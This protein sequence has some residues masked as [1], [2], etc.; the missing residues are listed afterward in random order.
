MAG[1]DRP[2]TSPVHDLK[3]T[4]TGDC[5]AA[6]EHAGQTQVLHR[7]PTKVVASGTAPALAQSSAVTRPVQPVAPAPNN[8]ARPAALRPIPVNLPAG[9]LVVQLADS[10]EDGASDD[11]IKRFAIKNAPPWLVSAVVH[12]ALVIILGLWIVRSARREAVDVE[13]RYSDTLGE[14]LDV[15]GLDGGTEEDIEQVE[16]AIS[17]L[18]SVDDPFAAPPKLELALDTV[19]PAAPQSEIAAPI[20]GSPLEGRGEGM[21]KALLRAYGGDEIT[22]AAV[23]LGLGWLAR[24]QRPD[25]TWSLKGP[26]VDGS[27]YENVEAATAMALLAFQG[28]GNTHQGGKYQ[29][30]V[31][32]GIK[33]LLSRQQADG[34][35]FERGLSNARLYTDALCTIAVCELYGMTRDSLL[36]G[37]A[38]LAANYC[39]EAQDPNLGGWK[40]IPRNDSDLSVSGW[41]L[42]GLQSARMAGI[43]VP[44]SVFDQAGLFLDQ[45][46]VSGGSRYGYMVGEDYSLA[47]TAEGLLSRQY[48]GWPRTDERLLEGTSFLLENLPR[49]EDRDVYYW[50]YGTQFMHHMEGDAWKQWNKTLKPLLTDHQTTT[51]TERGSWTPLGDAPDPWGSRYGGRLYTTCLSLYMLEVYYRHMPL[52]S[53]FVQ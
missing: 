3:E 29:E 42:M 1:V 2:K 49:W 45:V 18:E 26:Y 25:G 31:S 50:Y 12:M 23:Q 13:L 28:A 52:Y 9:K 16:V 33:A 4:A 38:E 44:Q 46:S 39:V 35:F 34:S 22:E 47:M 11:A 24:Q 27:Y 14:Q 37:P 21:R 48:L 30:H 41:V 15:S 5:P 32:R 51:G 6:K 10:V 19:G 53:K 40:Y 8:G 43:E 17:E 7:P 36:R 20:V